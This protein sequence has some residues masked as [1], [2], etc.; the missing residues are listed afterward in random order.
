M[1]FAPPPPQEKAEAES[2]LSPKQ[3]AVLSYLREHA[4]GCSIAELSAALGV[5]DNTLRSHLHRLVQLDLVQVIAPSRG[6]RGRP[7]SRYLARTPHSG[8][9]ATEYV[10]L[11]RTLV[12]AGQFSARE[13]YLVGT[14]W[15]ASLLPALTDQPVT[16]ESVLRSLGFDPVCSTSSSTTQTL[17]LHACPLSDSDRQ[18]PS[19][20]CQ[21][22]A[23]FLD[24][25]A[26]WQTRQ[27]GHQVRAHLEP[28]TAPG[29]CTVQV[30]LTGQAGARSPHR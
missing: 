10:S 16:I 23:G 11:I 30:A 5:H 18:V 21:I 29:V 27:S 12:A 17:E 8:A 3:A 15:A 26:S 2:A 19:P 4:E 9:I 22:H 6:Q 13:A 14:T 24:H 7:Q 28:C 1:N 20:V 25:C